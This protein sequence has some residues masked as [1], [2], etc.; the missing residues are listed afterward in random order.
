MAKFE[1]N[2]LFHQG[3]EGIRVKIFC[4]SMD[5][6]GRAE[7]MGNYI[8]LFYFISLY[9]LLSLTNWY[10][11]MQGFKTVKRTNR[12][13]CVY[14]VG[15]LVP[16]SSRPSVFTVDTAGFF[17]PTH[18]HVQRSFVIEVYCTNTDTW[19]DAIH[20]NNAQTS[21]Y[22]RRLPLPCN[23][24]HLSWDTG[25]FRSRH[26][27]PVLTTCDTTLVNLCTVRWHTFFGQYLN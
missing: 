9:L 19:K 15:Q 10:F 6:P 23:D 11:H 7:L 24:K 1:L 22:V 3:V 4:T 21:L 12:A 27:G 18:R 13:Q 20:H 26:D 25:V 16:H 8:F 2:E 17:P 14:T 5:T